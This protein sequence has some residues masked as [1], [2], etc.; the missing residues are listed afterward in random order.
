MP[1]SGSRKLQVNRKMNKY[2]KEYLFFYAVLFAR[3]QK[4]DW[5]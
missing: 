2:L 4:K 3:Q 5:G 1:L